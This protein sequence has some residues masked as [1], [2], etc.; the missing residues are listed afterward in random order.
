MPDPTLQCKF[1]NPKEDADAQQT[2]QR[3]LQ[4]GIKIANLKQE[5]KEARVLEF[6]HLW[7]HP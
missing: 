3:T 1:K 7:A 5:S 2:W 4:E 6:K